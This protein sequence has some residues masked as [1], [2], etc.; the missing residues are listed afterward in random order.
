M[1]DWNAKVIQEFRA[2]GGKVGGTFEGAPM[3]LLH[4]KGAKS[5]RAYVTPLM[6][7]QVGDDVAVFA[8]KGGAPENPAWY[9]NLVVNPDTEIELG[10]DTIAVHARVAEGEERDRIFDVQKERYSNFAEYEEKAQGLRTIPVVVL[11]R[12]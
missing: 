6:Y 4:T 2:N 7:Q 3:L 9:H 5:G 10:S 8:S 12:A 1:S 11:S